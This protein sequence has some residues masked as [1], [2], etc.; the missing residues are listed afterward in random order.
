MPTYVGQKPFH[1][2]LEIYDNHSFQLYNIYNHSA[3]GGWLR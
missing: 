3:I 2:M 1:E